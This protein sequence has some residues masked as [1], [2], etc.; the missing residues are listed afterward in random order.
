MPDESV[1]GLL[2]RSL[3]Q[4][5]RLR[6]LGEPT[7]FYSFVY[8]VVVGG[9]LSFGDL[10]L[11]Y[12]VVQALQAAVV[13]LVALP[14]YL[15]T[16][17]LATDG[18]GLVAAA[19]VLALPGLAYSGLVMTENVFVPL[20]IL[21]AWAA[22]RA[23]ETPT[24]RNQALLVGAVVAVGATRLQALVLV[25]VVFTAIG[26]HALLE[27]DRRVLVRYRYAVG[28]LVGVLILW[29]AWQLR[30]GG[31]LSK[32]FGAY[33][34]AGRSE[35]GGSPFLYVV[36]HA[37]DL[38]LLTGAF[39]VCALVLLLVAA[40]RR[41]ERSPA[42]RA[43]VAVAA[44]LTAWLVL[45]V[46]VFAAHHVGQLAER[47]LLGAAPV[48]FVGF[49][50]WL[51]RGAERPRWLTYGTALAA[52]ALVLTL[53]VKTFVTPAA[54]PDAFTLIPL[55]LHI[56]AG[57]R[58][59]VLFLAAAAG[60]VLFAVLPRSAIAVLPLALFVFLAGT[61]VSASRYVARQAELQQRHFLGGDNR[62]IDDTAPGDVVYVDAAEP[63]WNCVWETLFWNRRITEV[64]TLPRTVLNGPLPHRAARLGDDGVL[65]GVGGVPDYAV[66]STDATLAGDRLRFEAQEGTVQKGLQLWRIERPLR[67]LTLRT[68]FTPNDTVY[69]GHA[70]LVVYA[71]TGGTLTFT[72]L[73]KSPGVVELDV[74]RKLHQ[75]RSFP[76]PATWSGTI[77][78]AQVAGGKG[79]CSFEIRTNAL[80]ATT[81][82]NFE[83]VL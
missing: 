61:S 20:V 57:S 76:A 52:L 10:H 1:Y 45:E 81:Q 11:G 40:L 83:R 72:L 58:G 48:L 25:P 18:Y 67:L 19:L 51:S 63:E 41:R 75:R 5:G 6:I 36:Y 80:V 62:W 54:L 82:F 50:L 59:A 22:A 32:V 71:C 35:K 68:G 43:Y 56:S 13:S 60:L 27:R 66:I 7:A 46:G 42:V 30:H 31:P 34:S 37:A 74:N 79:A 12:K 73:V 28:G 53:P 14:V 38:V 33:H 8:P 16:R 3:Y 47:D 29:S 78:V 24:P 77:D 39:P 9:P 21:A 49:A 69:Q 64:A 44:S 4:H 17:R 15:W 55:W 65:R 70:R 23:L 26:L 2:G